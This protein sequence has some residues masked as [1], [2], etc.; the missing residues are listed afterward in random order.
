MFNDKRK[1]IIIVVA[2]LIIVILFIIYVINKSS[3]KNIIDLNSLIVKEN[4]DEIKVEEENSKNEENSEKCEES[5]TNIINE[6]QNS[7][8]IVVHITGEVKKEGVIYLAKGARIIDAIKEAGGE[9]KQADLSQVNLA[10]ELKDGQKLYI[11]N[12]N[13]KISEYIIDESGQNMGE[14]TRSGESELS[15]NEE[16]YNKNIKVNINTATLEELDNLP[17]IG[18]AIA[19]RI[20]EYREENGKFKN[21]E[22][23]QNVK[24]IGES[25]YN[26]IKEKIIV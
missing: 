4:T 16:Q 19:N 1:T 13:E 14:S 15:G 7:G 25:K 10:Y 23:I 20:I 12:K 17:G 26:D 9:T 22:D 11:P 5:D 6:K 2:I 3:A 21:I 18:P 24:G 8:T